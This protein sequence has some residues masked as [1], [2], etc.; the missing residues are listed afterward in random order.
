MA[1]D[2]YFLKNNLVSLGVDMHGGA[3]THFSCNGHKVN[4]LSFRFTKKQMPIVNRKGASFKGHFLCAGR[5]GSP[6]DAELKLGLPYHGEAS[7]NI[8]QLDVKTDRSLVMFTEG[9]KEHLNIKRTI[10][11]HPHQPV[12]YCSESITNGA[13]SGRL[14]NIV[15]HPTIAAPFLDDDTKIFCNADQGFH[16]EQYEKP[17]I[18]R[19]QWPLGLNAMQKVIQLDESNTGDTGVYSFVIRKDDPLGWIA[20]YSPV[21]NILFG[22]LWKRSNYPWINVWQH[23]DGKK[24]KYR[25]LEFGTTGVH[26]PYNKIISNGKL[27]IFDEPVVEYLDA[28]ETVRKDYLSFLVKPERDIAEITGAVIDGDYINLMQLQR[29]VARISSRYLLRHMH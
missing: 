12:W 24:I 16:F 25:G 5:W 18:F 27:R 8:W 13:F 17:E 15:Q 23:Y 11:L 9:K 4:P 28:G 29:T 14:F 19:S 3:I 7:N 21:Y 10:K 1:S 26:Q 2:V 22:Y 20:A 6:S